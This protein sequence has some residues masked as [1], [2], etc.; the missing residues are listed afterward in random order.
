MFE[1]GRFWENHRVMLK[2]KYC[3]QENLNAHGSTAA[4]RVHIESVPR[5]VCAYDAG[6]RSRRGDHRGDPG[7][8]RKRVYI[9]ISRERH[10]LSCAR[11][12][13]RH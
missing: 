5:E 6:F 2:R 13:R 7:R 11:S 3:N 12:G 1:F 8:C 10:A 4:L 9:V